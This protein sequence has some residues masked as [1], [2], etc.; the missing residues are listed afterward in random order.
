MRRHNFPLTGG[1]LGATEVSTVGQFLQSGK[2]DAQQDEATA[3]CICNVNCI[4]Q[5]QCTSAAWSNDS[6]AID[7]AG[8]AIIKKNKK[9]IGAYNGP[10]PYHPTVGMLLYVCDTDL[11]THETLETLRLG[12]KTYRMDSVL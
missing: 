12:H 1:R 8:R 4:L 6:L 9:S 11:D 5:S 7:T 3:C 10:I 2:G